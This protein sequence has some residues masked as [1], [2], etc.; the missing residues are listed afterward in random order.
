MEVA[1]QAGDSVA[2]IQA[3]VLTATVD[4]LVG[5][6]VL[7]RNVLTHAL[8]LGRSVSGQPA[9]SRVLGDTYRE[10]AANARH[11]G[12][13]DQAAVYAREGLNQYKT[14]RAFVGMANMHRE[15]AAAASSVRDFPTAEQELLSAL[16]YAP[17]RPLSFAHIW[18]RLGEL[19][20]QAGLSER[21][22]SWLVA[23]RLAYN[24]LEKP[25]PVGLGACHLQLSQ[26]WGALGRPRSSEADLTAAVALA[27][28][29]DNRL[30][31]AACAIEEARLR[32][33]ESRLQEAKEAAL[34]GLELTK[35]VDSPTTAAEAHDLL[36]SLSECLG[37]REQAYE[38]ANAAV[39][40]QESLGMQL[41][42]RPR[43]G[44][45]AHGCNRYTE[46][47]SP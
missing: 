5:R 17:D 41:T 35:M 6:Y 28:E 16:L 2:T 20:L 7:A 21:A 39:V 9:V 10:L 15:L 1:K 31:L 32:S 25:D 44:E 19:S 3:L 38:H 43:G 24:S 47:P 13:P 30:A 37:E 18:R 4:N 45:R 42:S 46:E 26:A 34:K 33:R 36:S 22:V 12:L 27:D 23:A 40:I 29:A 8:A 11:V 14:A